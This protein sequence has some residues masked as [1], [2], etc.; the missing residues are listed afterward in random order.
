M[1]L[2]DI[3]NLTLEIDTQNGWIKALDKINLV[4]EEGQ[5]HALVGESGSGKSIIVKAINGRSHELARPRFT[6]NVD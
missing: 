5:I 1:S 3:K 6:Q 4:I 2:L